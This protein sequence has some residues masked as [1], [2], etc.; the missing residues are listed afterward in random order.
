MYKEGYGMKKG[1]FGIA[2]TKTWGMDK[3][4]KGNPKPKMVYKVKGGKY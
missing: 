3:N 2:K 4:L 1:D